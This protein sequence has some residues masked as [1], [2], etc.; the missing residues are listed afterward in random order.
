[1]RA[2]PPMPAQFTRMRAVPLAASPLAIAALTSS[3]LVTSPTSATPLTSAATFSAF[4]LLWSSTAIFAPLAAIA[5]AVAAPRPEPPP[6]MRTETSFNCMTKPFLGR[7]LKF[8]SWFELFLGR[9]LSLI[10]S[11]LSGD[12]LLFIR[13]HAAEQQRFHMR[14]VIAAYLVGDG[15]YAGGA[16]HRMAAEEQMIAGADQARVE[17]DRI[18]F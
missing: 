1:M 11:P 15:T 7:F 12:G 5:R 10:S 3:S 13:Q 17:Q 16:R 18:D 4:S 6:V 2:E 9:F 8:S 14:D